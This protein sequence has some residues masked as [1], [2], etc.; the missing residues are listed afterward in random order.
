MA[1]V[2]IITGTTR[3]FGHALAR[4]VIANGDRLYSLSSAEDDTADQ[5]HNLN[6]DMSN[7]KL[8]ETTFER[9]IDPLLSVEAQSLILINNAGVLDPVG[10]I[11]TSTKPQM[12]RHMTI[13]YITPALLT[14]VFIRR[15]AGLASQRRIIN[16][17]SGA[18]RHPYAGWAM[19]C[20]AKAALEMM[21][22]CVAAEQS[23]K[24]DPVAV[25]AVCPGKV[26][27][28][29]QRSIRALRPD[30]FPA[31]PEF[32]AAKKRGDVQLPEAAAKVLLDADRAGLLRNGCIYDLR[33]AVY[34]GG[35]V[36][37]TPVVDNS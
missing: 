18:A 20:S 21:T 33:D 19:Y 4:R 32:V 1:Y 35:S 15:T 23:T 36:S 22:R 17:S 11:E 37:I 34:R 8:V 16:I 6:C 27:T 28:R 13:N 10:P 2:Y 29:M 3:G 25:C 24:E 26:E 12:L 14:A 9:L 30:Q 7:P 31:Q 5:W